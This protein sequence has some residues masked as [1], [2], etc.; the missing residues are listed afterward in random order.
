[1]G[2][3]KRKGKLTCS[4]LGR[5]TYLWHRNV[6]HMHVNEVVH[7]QLHRTLLSPLHALQSSTVTRK[8]KHNQDAQPITRHAAHP[9]GTDIGARTDE[10]GRDEDAEDEK[11]HSHACAHASAAWGV[12]PQHAR[13]E[14]CTSGHHGRQKS[15][16]KCLRIP[17]WS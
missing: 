16:A 7:K 6:H 9:L 14:A 4:S 3:T 8:H 5:P 13:H 1:M 17:P 10:G 15:E 2:Q 11:H 12:W